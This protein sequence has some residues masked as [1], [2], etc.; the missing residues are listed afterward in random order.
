MC[1]LLAPIVALPLPGEEGLGPPP[2]LH[3]PLKTTVEIPGVQ[4]DGEEAFTVMLRR[5][6]NIGGEPSLVPG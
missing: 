2:P 5:G 6:G 1:Y 3:A 4:G